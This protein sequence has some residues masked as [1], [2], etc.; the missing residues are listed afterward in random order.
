[1]HVFL[2]FLLLRSSPFSSESP[3]RRKRLSTIWM[4]ILFS[5][6]YLCLSYCPPKTFAVKRKM[7]NLAS[8]WH[9]LVSQVH[10]FQWWVSP[11][12]MLEDK[13]LV[14]SV[15]LPSR[16]PFL[17][18]LGILC[19]SPDGRSSYA[20]LSI[21]DGLTLILAPSHMLLQPHWSKLNSDNFLLAPILPSIKVNCAKWIYLV[22]RW[23]SH[24]QSHKNLSKLC[25]RK[26]NPAITIIII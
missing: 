4:L 22:L 21:I 7:F 3:F 8:P 16:Q 9:P 18:S 11:K 20:C 6:C 26:S 1:M 2:W 24:H 15:W 17:C 13:G 19:Y 12:H 25:K 23:T 10:H 14:I 5:T